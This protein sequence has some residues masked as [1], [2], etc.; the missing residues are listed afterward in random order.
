MM[1]NPSPQLGPKEVRSKRLRYAIVTLLILLVCGV[2]AAAVI[3]P[4]LFR[5]ALV[6]TAYRASAPRSTTTAQKSA[7]SSIVQPVAIARLVIEGPSTMN[8]LETKEFLIKGMDAFGNTIDLSNAL[9]LMTISSKDK[10]DMISG[11]ALKNFLDSKTN[12]TV[13]VVRFDLQTTAYQNHDLMANLNFQIKAL[14][15]VKVTTT[16]KPQL[17]IETDNPPFYNLGRQTNFGLSFKNMTLKQIADCTRNTRLTFYIEYKE[18]Q[19]YDKILN[20]GSL[21][22]DSSHFTFEP[23]LLA[24]P[25]IYQLSASCLAEGPDM[26]VQINAENKPNIVVAS[27][28]EP[29]AENQN[30]PQEAITKLDS[31]LESAQQIQDDLQLLKTTLQEAKNK[32]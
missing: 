19:G 23:Y 2:G 13:N 22:S 8:P 30:F 10:G 4:S 7:P 29:S 5:A 27:Y 15:Y 31:L 25:G 14:F 28:I 21:N 20:N 3:S 18:K 32:P 11:I 9:S 1:N 24:Y 12:K 16:L 6:G 26:E 17:V